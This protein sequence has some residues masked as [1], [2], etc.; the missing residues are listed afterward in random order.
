M[1]KKKWLELEKQRSRFENVVLK[2]LDDIHRIQHKVR[3]LESKL[4]EKNMLDSYKEME[5]ENEDDV[6]KEESEKKDEDVDNEEE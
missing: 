6:A 1:L 5:K 2:Q 4:R 3:K